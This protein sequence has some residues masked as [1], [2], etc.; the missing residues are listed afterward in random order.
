MMK[1]PK[2]IW[3]FRTNVSTRM[4]QH[5]VKPQLDRLMRK[6][7]KWNF[8]LEDCDHI[9]RVETSSLAASSIIDVLVHAGYR[10]EELEDVIPKVSVAIDLY[11]ID[12]L[13]SKQA[14]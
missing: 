11:E 5:K 14:I 9:L 1:P 10:C 13:R 3:V 2:T 4:D 6:D 7:D 8:D 12:H